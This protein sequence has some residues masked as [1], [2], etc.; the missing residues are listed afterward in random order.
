LKDFE[1]E[2]LLKI[3]NNIISFSSSP[4]NFY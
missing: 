1:T 4:S 3:I 2:V